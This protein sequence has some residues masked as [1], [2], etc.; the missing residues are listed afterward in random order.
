MH[1]LSIAVSLVEMAS[2]RAAEIGGPR[3]DAVHVRLGALSGVVEEALRFS[4]DLA[5]GGTPVDGAR[6]IVERVPV[7]VFCAGCR[8]ERVL[9]EPL[10]FLCPVCG[11]PAGDLV[12]GREIELTALEVDDLAAADR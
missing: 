8:A 2:E 6:L 7:A 11:A 12:H 10:R 5:A 1:E 4:F 9:A 3:V